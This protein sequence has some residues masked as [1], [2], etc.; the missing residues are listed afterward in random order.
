MTDVFENYFERFDVELFVVNEENFE[1]WE[2]CI[3]E[4]Y[5]FW[6]LDGFL[7]FEVSFAH[8]I[9]YALME[10][11]DFCSVAQRAQLVL[12]RQYSSRRRLKREMTLNDLRMIIL[13]RHLIFYIQPAVVVRST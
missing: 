3:F 1:S 10:V 9:I 4:D 13:S 7:S 6:Y 11:H 8:K 2:R 12:R 5:R